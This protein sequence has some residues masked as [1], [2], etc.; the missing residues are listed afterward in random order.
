MQL[1]SGR[2]AL[3]QSWDW[4]EMNQVLSLGAE[5]KGVPKSSE[6]SKNNIFISELIQKIHN[7]RN[8]K[9][10]WQMGSIL[11]LARLPSLTPP[12]PDSV[13]HLLSAVLNAVPV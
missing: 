2:W 8:T 3:T 1:G 11:A 5:F 9:H 7:E 12:D 4:G 6:I 13:P 10:V